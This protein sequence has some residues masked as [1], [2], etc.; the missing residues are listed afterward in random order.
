MT[1][2]YIIQRETW[3]SKVDSHNNEEPGQ[4]LLTQMEMYETIP[5][6]PRNTPMDDEEHKY[7][8]LEREQI[9]VPETTTGLGTIG[10]EN[11]ENYSKLEVTR[12]NSSNIKTEDN[13]AYC[14]TLRTNDTQQ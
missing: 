6:L 1:D 11:K 14:F 3:T 8:V 7:A 10:E 5:S 9:T 12:I 13:P 4:L 2:V